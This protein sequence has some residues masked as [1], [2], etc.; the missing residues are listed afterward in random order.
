MAAS[1][2]KH[3]VDINFVFNH[4]IEGEELLTVIKE[5][6]KHFLFIRR[7]LPVPF[8]LLEREER[9]LIQR[10]KKDRHDLGH[11]KTVKSRKREAAISAVRE[12]TNALDHF[13]VSRKVY[14]LAILFG[15]TVVTPKEVFLLR[16]D[17]SS[18]HV[19][20]YNRSE[21]DPML[22]REKM[23][24]IASELNKLGR[25]FVGNLVTNP[26]LSSLGDI[27]PTNVF[28]LVLAPKD[29]DG[30]SSGTF[31]PKQKYQLPYKGKYYDIVLTGETKMRNNDSIDKHPADK[32]LDV[33]KSHGLIWYQSSIAIKGFSDSSSGLF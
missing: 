28:I 3:V 4:S 22:L 20:D 33:Q 11:Y 2:C 15:S 29:A 32:L 14:A 7:Q 18:Q 17:F 21:K 16:H 6:I 12:T 8:L 24:T 10:G 25:S 9:V 13:A 26:I 5:G 27:R 1:G 31:I 19:L 30:P 23:K